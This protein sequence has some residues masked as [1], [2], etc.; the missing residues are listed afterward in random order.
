MKRSAAGRL[1]RD[2]EE[3]SVAEYAVFMTLLDRADNDTCVVPD[4]RTPSL[5]QMA[6]ESKVSKS[7]VALGLDHLERHGWLSRERSKGG[8]GAKTSYVLV[9]G[10]VSPC[11]CKTVRRPDRLRQPRNGP[12]EPRNGPVVGTETVRRD[13]S[14]RRSDH[15]MHQGHLGEG[16]PGMGQ[17][18][19]NVTTLPRP[20]CAVTGCERPARR[21]CRT[22][23][24]HASQE[25]TAS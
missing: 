15:A 9:P 20:T 23:W 16:V 14:F 12:T 19:T 3:L 4:R 11:Q 10:V 8:R 13:E 17:N 22:C 2:S 7:T 25:M 18:D 6:L 5:R 21:A 1:A 24:E